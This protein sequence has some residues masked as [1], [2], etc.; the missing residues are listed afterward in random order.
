M[1]ASKRL[2]ARWEIL[3]SWVVS[4]TTGNYDPESSASSAGFEG[5]NTDPSLQPFR[6]GRVA[7]DATHVGKLFG[8]YRLPLRCRHPA[9]L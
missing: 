7:G 9:R 6:T 4:K 1:T 3:A 8:T 2:A 5:P